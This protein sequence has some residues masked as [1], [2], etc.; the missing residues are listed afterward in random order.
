MPKSRLIICIED[1][2]YE[3][4]FTNC[5]LNHYKDQ[6]ELHIYN[7]ME[8]LERTNPKSYDVAICAG[9]LEQ[10]LQMDNTKGIPILYL[11]D[12]DENISNDIRLEV[13]L[14]FAEKYQSVNLI[15]DEVLKLIGNEVREI[16]SYITSDKP[17]LLAVYSLSGSEFQLPFAVTLGSILGDRY[18]TLLVDLQENSGLTKMSSEKKE[19]GLEDML[20]MAESGK[21]SKTRMISCIGHLEN[22]DYIYPP[23]NSECVCEISYSTYKTLF[24][25]LTRELNYQL[26]IVNL[27]GRFNGFFEMISESQKLFLLVKNGGLVKWREMEFCRELEQKGHSDIQDKMEDVELPLIQNPGMDCERVVQQWKWD[28]FGNLIRTLLTKEAYFG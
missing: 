26:I 24:L 25:M 17:Q 8:F 12:M 21:F 1:T 19:S 5:L 10:I 14:S 27:G 23:D 28:E 3:R 20:V 18:K 16:S 22:F 11:Y 13:Q 6:F 4:R 15:V 7:T 9:C 2:E